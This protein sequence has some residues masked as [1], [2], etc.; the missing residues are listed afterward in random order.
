MLPVTVQDQIRLWELEKNRLKSQ[1]GMGLPLPHLPLSRRPLLRLRKK[2]SIPTTESQSPLQERTLPHPLLT[3][4]HSNSIS[5][6]LFL[7][8]FVALFLSLSVSLTLPF[9]PFPLLFHPCPK[10]KNLMLAIHR[11]PIHFLRLPSG[12][13]LRPELR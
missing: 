5:V 8:P 9:L 10:N 1:E 12:L 4:P 6:F 2:A 13:R 11:V 7:F 3:R